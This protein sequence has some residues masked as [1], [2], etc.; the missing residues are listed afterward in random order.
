[1]NVVVLGGAVTDVT[2]RV[3]QCPAWGASV[4][5]HGGGMEP[6]GKGLNQAI[7][8]ARMGA[9]VAMIAAIGDDHGGDDLRAAMLA[10]GIDHDHVRT[11]PGA[12]SPMTAVFVDDGGNT[13]FV[14]WK[15][16]AQLGPARDAVSAA[17]ERIEAADALMISLEVPLDTVGHAVRIAKRGG[18]RV[19][20]NPAPPPD[21]RE[22]L[23]DRVLRDVDILIPNVS[24]AYRLAGRSREG[25]TTADLMRLAA[26]LGSTGA[27][28][29]AITRGAD[30]CVTWHAGESAEHP[31]F[32]ADPLDTTGG[33]DAFCA[34][35]CLALLRGRSV[36]EAAREANAAGALTV[37]VRGGAASMPSADDVAQY[38]V[39]HR[40]LHTAGDGA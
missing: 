28:T 20:L 4:Q 31:G 22:R 14:G 3:P 32:P 21:P 36:S 19:V 16:A 10:H 5:A 15:N 7:A 34:A 26:D 37:G 33:S 30:G 8:A 39:S 23:S 17:S 40:E 12:T 27:G 11:I 29:V 9:D 2:M 6:G 24:E 18:T 35:F 38:L 13:A 25:H 1:M